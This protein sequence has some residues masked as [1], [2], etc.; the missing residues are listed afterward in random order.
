MRCT[1]IFIGFSQQSARIE[2]SVCTRD[3]SLHSV[4]V[5]SYWIDAERAS[6]IGH[7]SLPHQSCGKLNQ[8][9][10]EQTSRYIASGESS[11]PIRE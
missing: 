8:R 5:L 9:N 7:M 1:G 6:S 4:N 11:L 3:I 2:K 10:H